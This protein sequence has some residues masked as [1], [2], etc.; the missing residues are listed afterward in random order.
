M[1]VLVVGFLLRVIGLA[2]YAAGF[3]ADEVNQG[4]TAY[5]ILKTGRD[6]WGKFLPLAP[7][8]YGDYRAPLYTY[9]T[10]PSIAVLGLNE[11]AVRLPGVVLGTILLII[12]IGGALG[13]L[14]AGGIFDIT[15]SYDL[16]FL[17][18]TIVSIFGFLS[19]VLLKIR[20]KSQ[21]LINITT[22]TL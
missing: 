18:C 6:E 13:P 12:N 9:L 8:S 2:Y 7:R 19:A 16:T 4:Y 5:S 11:F 1:G 17:V 22:R 10:I 15:G 21:I 20:K 14:V 3:N